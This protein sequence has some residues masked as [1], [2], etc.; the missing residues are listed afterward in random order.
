MI[1]CFTDH[2]APVLTVQFDPIGEFLVSTFTSMSCV[3][4]GNFVVKTIELL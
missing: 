2:I 1:G 4:I 3:Y